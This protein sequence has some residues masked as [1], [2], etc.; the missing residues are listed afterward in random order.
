VSRVALLAVLL[1]A[2]LAVGGAPPSSPAPAA[3]FYLKIEGIEG[4]A[5]GGAIAVAGLAWDTEA[6]VG[7]LAVDP[8]AD[9]VARYGGAQF[10]GGGMTSVR[11]T[12]APRDQAT[13]MASGRRQHQPITIVKAVDKASPLLMEACVDGDPIPD[14]EVWSRESGQSQLRYTLKEALITSITVSR[15]EDGTSAPTESVSFVFG[16]IELAAQ[17]ARGNLNSSKSN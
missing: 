8:P 14:I 2:A 6:D 11:E 1:S 13:G 5:E 12:A 17:G 10:A 9:V 4:E 16:R 15:G 7:Q 3:D